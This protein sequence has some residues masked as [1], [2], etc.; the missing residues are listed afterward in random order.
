MNHEIEKRVPSF[1]GTLPT[2]GTRFELATFWS[3]ARRSIQLSYP[4]ISCR[5]RNNRYITLRVRLCQPFFY[6]FIKYVK[7]PS[8]I[9]VLKKRCRIV[10]VSG[11]RKNRY[12]CLS[13]VGR[14][15]RD[16]NCTIQRSSGRNTY[17]HTLLFG[18]EL[19]C[20]KCII[21]RDRHDRII[22]PRI[23]CI[24]YKTG[25]D[26]LDLMRSARSAFRLF[27]HRQ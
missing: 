17:K 21:V 11:I 7:Y 20:F 16:L 5:F 14:I 4:N 1:D 24:R 8:T 12:D 27:P 23:Q 13:F 6:S 3:V 15:L 26:S 9:S 18:D 2:F 10:S 22:N 25:A 19:S